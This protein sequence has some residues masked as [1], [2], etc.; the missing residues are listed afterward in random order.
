[1]LTASKLPE[2]LWE[3]AVAHA[4]YLQN[5]AYTTAVKGST[6]YQHWFNKKPDVSHLQEFGAPVW[7]LLQ[8]QKVPRKILPKSQRHAYV[9]F[10]DGSNTV[11]FYNAEMQKILTLRNF[12]FLM[13]VAHTPLPEEIVIE[14]DPPREGELPEDSTHQ[15]SSERYTPECTSTELPDRKSVV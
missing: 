3:P 4:A 13:P 7:I 10:D 8:G 2:F 9:R 14:P 1:M 11:K 15:V 6:P 5:Q 12:R